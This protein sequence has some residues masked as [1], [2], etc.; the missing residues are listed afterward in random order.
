MILNLFIILCILLGIWLTICL[1]KIHSIHHGADELRTEF[2]ARLRNDT[3]VGI[4]ISTSDKKMRALAA[5]MDRQLKLLR[6][7]HIRYALGDSE[8][9][10]AVSS[11]SHDLRTPLTAICGYIDLLAR[12]ETSD[13]VR[14]YLSVISGRTGRRIVSLFRDH[15]CG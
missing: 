11:I 13:T 6:K 15:V 10:S 1:I 7:E 12:E 4:D 8:L 5:D 3:N 14:E 2:A 9:K